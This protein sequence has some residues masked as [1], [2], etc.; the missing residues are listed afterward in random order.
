[1]AALRQLP[2]TD[3]ETREARRFRR[4]EVRLRVAMV[5]D[6]ETACIAHT[7]NMS[8]GGMLV[9]DYRGPALARGRIVGVNL[10]GVLDDQGNTDSEPYLMRVVRQREGRVALRFAG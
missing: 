6:R 8:E 7:V 4:V 5:I 10:R 2:D 1:M 9:E 3:S